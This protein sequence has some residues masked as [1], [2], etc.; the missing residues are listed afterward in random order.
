MSETLFDLEKPIK[1]KVVRP[2]GDVLITLRYPSNE[3]WIERSRRRK[4]RTRNLGGGKSQSIPQSP[5]PQDAELVNSLRI[6]E[7]PEVD[8]YEAKRI[9]DSLGSVQ[10]DE[11]PVREGSII[12]VPMRARGIDLV[13]AL[14]IPTERE[15]GSFLESSG[16]PVISH[17]SIDT[18]GFNLGAAEATY[19]QLC[20]ESIG[21]KGMVPVPHMLAAINAAFEFIDKQLEGDDENP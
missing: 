11:E 13:H 12:R 1:A 7:S 6:D 8:E 10:I 2:D 16:I 9:L 18:Y 14:R 3:Q 21:Y 19:R 20:Q 5:D 15:R 4:I 17:G